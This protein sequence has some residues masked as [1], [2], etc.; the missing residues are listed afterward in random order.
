MVQCFFY[1]KSPSAGL[2][3]AETISQTKPGARLRMLGLNFKAQSHQVVAVMFH[4]PGHFTA[5]FN[6][7][8]C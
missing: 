2:S 5:V 1:N 6:P 7:N 8:V 3:A 4:Q